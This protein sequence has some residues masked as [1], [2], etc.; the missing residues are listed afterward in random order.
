M[1]SDTKYLYAVSRIKALETK[2][3][4][5]NV[6]ERMLDA[7]SA[8]EAL[9]VLGETDY[10]TS[11]GE[12]ES[13]YDF[14]KVLNSEL[15]KVYKV[16]DDSTR[17]SR[18][19]QMAK[20]R[21]DFHNL[22]VMLKSEYLGEN[23]EGITVELG[24]VPLETMARAVR[25]KDYTELPSALKKAAEEAVMDFEFNRDPQRIDIILDRQLFAALYKTAEDIG[26]EAV[27]KFLAT[28]IDLIN[29]NIFVRTK[30]IGQDAR[31]LENALID[32]GNLDK[33]LFI[34][35]LNEPLGTFID[36]LSMSVYEEVAREGIQA[37]VDTGSTTLLEKLS[38][39]FL[40]DQAKKG[41]F[42]AFGVEPIIGYLRAKENEVKIIRII[43]VGKI[44]NIPSDKIRER[45]RDVYV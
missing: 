17:D 38:D 3:L 14:E 44:N 29:I 35:S 11:F 18:F 15:K 39:D 6:I 37:V 8:D 22:K 28:E 20:L 12:L 31:F 4:S 2:L 7:S 36:K 45:L 16:I 26:F 24:A 30:R 13:V 43:M 40:L 10:G 1:P 42:T 33:S 23:Y 5:R 41:K 21:H 27:K 9:K 19:T 32:N 25:E 34:E